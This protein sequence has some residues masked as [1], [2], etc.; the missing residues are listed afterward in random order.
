MVCD[1]FPNTFD[2]AAMSKRKSPAVRVS[3]KFCT[4]TSCLGNFLAGTPRVNWRTRHAISTSTTSTK[5]NMGTDDQ[6]RPVQHVLRPHHIGILAV[7][8]LV[9]HPQDSKKLPSQFMLHI[10]RVLLNEV[11]E[12]CRASTI[13]LGTILIFSNR[14]HNL[15]R[16][17]NSSGI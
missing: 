12:V 9:F 13:T 5:D 2:L 3:S 15:D 11:S 8:L 7:F 4:A 17:T 6:D 16:T 14:W 1:L 10:H